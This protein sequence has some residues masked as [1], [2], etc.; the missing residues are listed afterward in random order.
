MHLLIDLQHIQFSFNTGIINFSFDLVK[1]FVKY[2]NWDI[3]LLVW[4]DQEGFIDKNLGID[5][6]KIVVPSHLKKV[7]RLRRG[8]CPSSVKKEID[9]RGVDVIL[10]VCFTISSYL[11]PKKYHQIGVIHDIQLLKIRLQERDW[12]CALYM[13]SNMFV[14]YRLLDKLVTISDFVRH[15]V[16]KLCGRNSTVIYNSINRN[17]ENEQDIETIK[18]TPYILDVN[19]FF[20]Y[21]NTENLIRAFSSIKDKIPH[22]LYLKG[23]KDDGIRYEELM[24]FIKSEGC[25]ERIIMDITNRT[26]EEMN[27]LYHHAD[28]FVSPSFMEGFGMTPI[29]AAF[30]KAPVA[31]SNIGTLVEVTDGLVPTFDPRSVES[32]SETIL[33]VLNNPPSESDLA[34]I[35]DHFRK[36]YSLENQ[37]RAYMSLIETVKNS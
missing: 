4:D 3:V 9:K 36:K 1:G 35:A 8:L 28:L 27:Y 15:D 21:K 13:F 18:N 31:V 29:E 11:Y 20:K 32:I 10:T 2:S 6:P 24:Q 26:T 14:Y 34:H 25:E 7:S 22:I 17:T 23:Y 16:K 19:S 30:H 12:P 5:L 37:V 33:K